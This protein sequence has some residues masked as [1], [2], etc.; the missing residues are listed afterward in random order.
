M[1]SPPATE[2]EAQVV[3]VC[4]AL[5]SRYGHE[6]TDVAKRQEEAAVDGM[7]TTWARIVS[8]LSD[9][10]NDPSAGA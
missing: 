3:A 8:K 5:S 7:A 1:N 10:T 2:E 9:M 6:A 4:E